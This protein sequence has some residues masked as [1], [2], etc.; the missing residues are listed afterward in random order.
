MNP[1]VYDD[2]NGRARSR[3]QVAEA[4]AGLPWETVVL[5]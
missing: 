5:G 4:L 1:A 3:E 2:K